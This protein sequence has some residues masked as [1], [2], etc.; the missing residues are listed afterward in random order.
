MQFHT[1]THLLC[2]LAPQLVN[3]CS[4]TPNVNKQLRMKAPKK[5]PAVFMQPSRLADGD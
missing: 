3:G 1:T 2:H 5:L 4:I